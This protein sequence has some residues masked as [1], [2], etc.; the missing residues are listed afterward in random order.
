MPKKKTLG[1]DLE[2]RKHQQLQLGEIVTDFSAK[3]SGLKDKQKQLALLNSVSKGLYEEID[4]LSKKAPAE[5]VTDL[6][7]VQI[8][9]VIRETKQLIDSD[10]Y[11]QR[12]DE[13]VPAGDNPQ[14]RDAVIVLRQ[15]RQSLERFGTKINAMNDEVSKHLRDAKGLFAAIRMSLEAEQIVKQKQ[16][17]NLVLGVS[18]FWL[19]EGFDPL[20]LLEKLDV[21][22]IKE[23]FKVDTV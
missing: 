1:F 14:H 13:F 7:L 12:L 9:D 5:M 22:D 2:A 23:Y 6:A 10:P 4:K 16:L 20:V 3:L 11:I 17:S 19:S 18:S 8:N 21:I 15:L